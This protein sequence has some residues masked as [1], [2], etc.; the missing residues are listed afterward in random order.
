MIVK[1][2]LISIEYVETPF[3][4]GK[5]SKLGGACKDKE[6]DQEGMSECDVI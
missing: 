2:N 4:G 1:M 6:R 3:G 5:Q